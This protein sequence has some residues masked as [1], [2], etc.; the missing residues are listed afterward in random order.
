MRRGAEIVFSCG[1]AG[2]LAM[3]VD[4]AERPPIESRALCRALFDVYLGEDPIERDGKRNAL[5]GFAGLLRP[6]VRR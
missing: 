6:S 2:R 1:P 5:A 3:T 4:G